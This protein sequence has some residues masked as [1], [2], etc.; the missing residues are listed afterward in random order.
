MKRKYDE[1]GRDKIREVLRD[2]KKILDLGCNVEKIFPD[3]IGI[4]NGLHM[5]VEDTLKIDYNWDLN[6]ITD[7]PKCDGICMSHTLEHLMNTR[8]IL[9]ICYEAL[10]PNG[11]IAITVP[12]GENVGAKTL[13]DSSL[14]HERLFTPITLKLFLEHAGFKNVKSEYYERPNAYKQTKG[15]F[16]YGEK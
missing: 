13:G 14:T 16:V 5:S 4:D 15:I 7:L 11:K 6:T 1:E 12:D 2:C 8:N 3:A 10:Q 9:R